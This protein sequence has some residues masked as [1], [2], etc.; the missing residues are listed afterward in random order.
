MDLPDSPLFGQLCQ[1]FVHG[2]R[3]WSWRLLVDGNAQAPKGWREIIRFSRMKKPPFSGRLFCLYSKS[4]A[5]MGMSSK[6]RLHYP[7]NPRSTP[8]SLRRYAPSKVIWSRRSYACI[9]A[10]S[11][12][13]AI[14]VAHNTRPPCVTIFPSFSA[15][16][17][18]K[19]TVPSTCSSRP[20]IT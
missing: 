5:L 6:I 18:W 15:V 9:R 7:R 11:A 17:A 2:C 19:T 4:V 20:L 14:P 3:S 8:I 12:L 13:S 16:P 1:L 10:C